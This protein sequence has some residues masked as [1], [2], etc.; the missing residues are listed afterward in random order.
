MIKAIA[1]DLGGVLFAEGNSV[2]AEK[3]SRERGYSRELILEVFVSPKSIELRKGLIDDAEF[4]AW[5][6]Q[7]FPGHYDV[8]LIKREWYSAYLL[9]EDVLRL[10]TKLKARYRIM[11]FSGNIKSRI[12]FLEEKYHFRSLFDVEVYSFMHGLSKWDRGFAE[13]MIRESGVR[14]G[15]IVYVDDNE[16]HALQA[17]KLGVKVV[18]YARGEIQELEKQLVSSGVEV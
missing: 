1:F 7:Q 9:D 11:A 2:S 14:P 8:Q 17:E 13:A 5:A 18:I 3:L 4:W 15:E 12:D 10:I 6:Q 16:H